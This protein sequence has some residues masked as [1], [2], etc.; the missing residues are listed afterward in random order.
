MMLLS[1]KKFMRLITLLNEDI[2]WQNSMSAEKKNPIVY[3]TILSIK[4]NSI[5]I[6]FQVRITYV[7]SK[8]K[9]L[10]NF[11]KQIVKS[12]FAFSHFARISIFQFWRLT[13][14]IFV[15]FLCG[16]AILPNSCVTF[17][18]QLMHVSF[19]INAK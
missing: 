9:G 13:F 8:S 6:F 4:Y 11:W 14:L 3:F 17:Q 18:P 15:D 7:L 1:H 10:G 16:P 19:K 12:I 2:Q 5:I